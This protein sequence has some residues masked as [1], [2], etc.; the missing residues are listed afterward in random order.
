[1]EK[2]CPTYAVAVVDPRGKV[3]TVSSPRNCGVCGWVGG[4]VGGYMDMD[5]VVGM[6]MGV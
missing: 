2:I 5:M 6:V 1:M 3:M 4:W